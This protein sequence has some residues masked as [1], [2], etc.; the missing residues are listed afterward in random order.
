LIKQKHREN[1]G[2]IPFGDIT[3][4]STKNYIPNEFDI[5]CAGFPYQVFS[6]N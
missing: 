2:E 5:L 6:I 3:K 4:K 1:F